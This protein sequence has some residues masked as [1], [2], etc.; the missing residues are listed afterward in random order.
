MILVKKF[1]N[2]ETMITSLIIVSLIILVVIYVF[3]KR[4]SDEKTKVLH[5]ELLHARDK[6]ISEN[7]SYLSSQQIFLGSR[8][9]I[10]E[11][12]SD[13]NGKY[14]FLIPK[15][16]NTTSSVC[17]TINQNFITNGLRTEKKNKVNPPCERTIRDST[18][19]ENS[20]LQITQ[21]VIGSWDNSNKASDS[22]INIPTKYSLYWLNV[23]IYDSNYP[24]RYSSELRDLNNPSGSIVVELTYD[25]TFDKL[26]R[27]KDYD[28]ERYKNDEPSYCKSVYYDEELNQP[29]FH[30]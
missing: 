12:C 28:W 30:F 24:K 6:I 20:S 25:I 29:F 7:F 13:I 18:E 16:S 17:K 14:V 4:I 5:D 21:S 1:I 23:D 27:E 15:N 19:T 26:E 11:N 2:K 22:N 9:S 8:Y 3:M 10:L